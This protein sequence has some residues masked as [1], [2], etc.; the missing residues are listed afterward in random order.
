MREKGRRGQQ[1]W[2]QNIRVDVSQGVKT[3]NGE[4]WKHSKNLSKNSE[5]N[6]D[7]D[8]GKIASFENV[9][10][11]PFMGFPDKSPGFN[12]DPGNALSYIL[13]F[14]YGEIKIY[15]WEKTE[16]F[17]DSSAVKKI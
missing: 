2:F 12:F 6:P 17:K 1:K 9:N 10:T 14:S 7:D 13:M 3:E 16:S 4:S 5:E 11:N 8:G 15:I